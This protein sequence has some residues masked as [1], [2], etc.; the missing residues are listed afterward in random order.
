MD[1][2][3]VG[4]WAGS[5]RL[6]PSK[7][8]AQPQLQNPRIAGAGDASEQTGAER[9]GRISQVHPVEGVEEFRPELRLVTV[10]I[11][12]H[13]GFEHGKISR[14]EARPDPYIAPRH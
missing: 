14:D 4:H 3:R 11:R 7:R 9:R 6:P 5:A 1:S 10:R 13:E 2:R 8:I 12:H